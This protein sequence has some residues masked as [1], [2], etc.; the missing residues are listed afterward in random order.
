MFHKVVAGLLLR[1]LHVHRI[2]APESP[3]REPPFP[4]KDLHDI[5]RHV[6]PC[7]PVGVE[8]VAGRIEINRRRPCVEARET[9]A[10]H[11]A[12][13]IDSVEFVDPR[14][15]PGFVGLVAF[16]QFLED[17]LQARGQLLVDSDR[18]DRLRSVVEIHLVRHRDLDDRDLAGRTVERGETF[19]ILLRPRVRLGHHCPQITLGRGDRLRPEE[20]IGLGADRLLDDLDLGLVHSGLT[21]FFPSPGSTET[22][23]L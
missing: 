15:A 23:T 14:L 7:R 11:L 1:G 8:P 22:V 2:A 4:C 9:A 13:G 12:V 16:T 5:E 18:A 3:C 10:A 20:P 6:R 17:A 21:T 19:L